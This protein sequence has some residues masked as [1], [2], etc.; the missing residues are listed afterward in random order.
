MKTFLKLVRWQNLLFLVASLCLIQ[1]AMINP[2]Y[3]QTGFEK[4]LSTT[5]VIMIVA[6][7]TLIT[8]GGYAINDYFDVKI[9]AIN[10][11]LTRIVGRLIE[12]RTAMRY[13][14]LLTTT[15]VIIGLI[16]AAC[17]HSWT[18]GILYLFIPGMLW[19]YS[20]SYKRQMLI[21][22]II[23]ALQVALMPIMLALANTAAFRVNYAEISQSLISMGVDA[24]QIEAELQKPTTLIYAV[25][26][27][28][29]GAY[30]L[31]MLIREIIKDIE[32]LQGDRELECHTLPIRIGISGTKA[33]VITLAI[34]TGATACWIVSGL[35][36]GG[37][38]LRF[39]IIGF[40]IPLITCCIILLRAKSRAEYRTARSLT[41]FALCVISAYAIQFGYIM[42]GAAS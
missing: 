27:C 18:I 19:F 17:L 26:G 36:D 30:F 33:V 4:Q 39:V 42:A 37:K 34:I 16:A 32:D 11:P 35:P 38:S 9:D 41:Q 21:G 24:T 29:A 6:S 28:M 8:A 2:L 10:R 31:T 12:R 3:A 23:I 25:I 5:Y 7:L 13:H 20:S 1:A 14:Q 22:N 15:G 40:V